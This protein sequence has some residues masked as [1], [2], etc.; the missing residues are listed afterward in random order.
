M[1]KIKEL[2]LQV[3]L[4]AACATIVVLIGGVFAAT[5]F[6]GDAPAMGESCANASDSE[7]DSWVDANKGSIPDGV[8]TGSV[9]YAVQEICSAAR[10]S[11]TPQDFSSELLQSAVGLSGY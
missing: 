11:N 4:I 3:K 8:D 10:T 7:I 9:S 1:E 5:S 6:I 2:S